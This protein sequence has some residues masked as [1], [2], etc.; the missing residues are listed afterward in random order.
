MSPACRQQ[1]RLV[2]GIL[3]PPRRQ[4]RLVTVRGCELLFKLAT[5]YYRYQQVPGIYSIGTLTYCVRSDSQQEDHDADS[6]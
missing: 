6:T 1:Y 4:G 3:R 5:T 2:E